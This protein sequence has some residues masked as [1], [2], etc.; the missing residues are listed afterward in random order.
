LP[1]REERDAVNRSKRMQEM[2]VTTVLLIF[3]EKDSIEPLTKAILKVY[4]ENNIEGEVLLGDDGST[5]GSFEICDKLSNKYENVRTFHHRADP[6][7][8]HPNDNWNRAW[9]ILH[10]FQRAEGE[11]SIIMDGDYQYDPKEIPAMID[12]INEG[13]DVVSGYRGNRADTWHRRFISSIYNLLFISTFFRIRIKDQNSGFKAFKTRFARKMRF[14]P[15]GYRGIHRFILPIAKY[16]GGKIIEIPVSHFDRTSGKS[17]IKTATV[18]FIFLSDLLF[19]FI[20]QF[21]KDIFSGR[22]RT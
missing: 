5:D 22:R 3:N 8:G 18:P 16:D 20:P 10:G 7:T 13:F 19:R 9:T 4:E 14:D 15:T 1:I 12:K 17:Y 6:E 11:I 21:R 2:L